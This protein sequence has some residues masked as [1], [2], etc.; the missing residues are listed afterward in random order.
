MT[1]VKI[2]KNFVRPFLNNFR[3]KHNSGYCNICEQDTVF[4]EYDSWLRDY[5]KCPKCGSIPRNRALINAINTFYP[6]WEKLKIHESS[7]GGPVSDFLDKKAADYSSSHFYP[8][9]ERGQYNGRF[10]SED[11]TNLTFEGNLFDLFISSD[12]FE[13]VFNPDLAFKEIARVLKPGGAHIFTMPWYPSLSQSR[14]RAVLNGQEIELTME[15]VYH[16]NPIDENGS[17]V[18]MDWG[19]DFCDFIFKSSGLVT[20]I[21]LKKDRT[22]GLD[23]EFLEVFISRKEIISIGI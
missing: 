13:H 7:P 22:L 19:I 14:K 10:R 2:F 17:L 12:V 5:Y 16:G 3:Y 1:L 6:E 11:L 8:N 15:P 20:T 18:T 21:Y 9:V 23:A 4:F